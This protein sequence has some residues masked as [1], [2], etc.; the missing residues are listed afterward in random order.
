MIKRLTL[1]FLSFI[2]IITSMRAQVILD[3]EVVLKNGKL[4]PW[5]E[6]H[7]IMLWSM[8][9]L[10]YC[11]TYKTSFGNDPLYL[12]TSKLDV[13]GTFMYKQNNQ[14][15][16][17]YF[18]MKTYNCY[19]AY[20]GDKEA[21]RPVEN[22]IKRVAYYH[23]PE[24]WAWPD[25]PRTQDDSP[26]GEYTDE[27]GEVDKICMV[28]IGYINYFKHTGKSEYFTKA[29]H[30]ARTVMQQIRPGDEMHSPLPFRTNLRTG[31]IVDPYTANIVLVIQ[32]FDELLSSDHTTL[33]KGSLTNNRELLWKWIMDYPMKNHFWS[34]YYEDV[35]SDF[36]NLNQQIPMETAR[37]ILDHP[38]MDPDY[39]T[40]VPELIHWVENRFGQVKRFGATSIKEQDGCFQEMSSHTARYASVV[41]KWFGVC[42][43]E[44]VREEARASFALATYSAYNKYSRDQMGINYTGIEYIEPWFSDSYWDYMPHY[45]GGFSEMP[46]LLPDNEDHIFYSSSVITN[47]IYCPGSI[48]YSAYNN[49]G[50]ERIKLN[51]EPKVYTNGKPLAKKYWYFGTFRGVENILVIKREGVKEIEIRGK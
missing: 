37:Y 10:K 42:L 9:F 20:S 15:S 14:G 8:N 26:D 25:V 16:N 47:I 18:G 13:D 28:A 7:N 35:I 48:H 51:F 33:D 12:V 31:E 2:C 23:T 36:S 43:D 38:E 19:Y 44:K 3:H 24:D 29:E 22:L 1:L 21:L 49:S 50:T 40:H 41:A 5:T 27:W 6:Y 45:F 30:I 32:L 46:E 17:V 34:G 11:P 39:K 4:M